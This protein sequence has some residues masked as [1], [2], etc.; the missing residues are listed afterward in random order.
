MVRVRLVLRV[1]P[2]LRFTEGLD[3][4]SDSERCGVGFIGWDF[5]HGGLSSA[6]AEVRK[7][8]E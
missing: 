7:Q 3:R 5:Y 8:C 1:L 4:G 6:W 2:Q